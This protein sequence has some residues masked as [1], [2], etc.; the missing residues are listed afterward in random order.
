MIHFLNFNAVIA[1]SVYGVVVIT[2]ILHIEDP[3]LHP[4]PQQHQTF[5]LPT[6]SLGRLASQSSYYILVS[7]VDIPEESPR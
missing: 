3:Y 5:S 7:M 1:S 6:E 2:L 4:R